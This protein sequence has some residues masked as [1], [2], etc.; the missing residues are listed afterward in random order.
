[1]PNTIDDLRTHLF[2]TLKALKDPEKPME[3]ERAREI[4]NVS[5]VIVDSAK[6]EVEFARVTGEVA[7]TGFMPQ[8]PDRFEGRRL[9]AVNEEL[10]T[11]E[12]RWLQLS[13]Q[14]DNMG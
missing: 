8:Q 10:H 6:V 5:R 13:E 11:L 3:L 1:M 9:K 14:I 4:A 7:S 12:E 2:D